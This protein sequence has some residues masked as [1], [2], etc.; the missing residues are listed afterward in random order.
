MRV[1]KSLET[2]LDIFL[3]SL[4][5]SATHF[6]QGYALFITIVDKVILFGLIISR[7]MNDDPGAQRSSNWRIIMQIHSWTIT[8]FFV[9]GCRDHGKIRCSGMSPHASFFSSLFKVSPFFK[10][11]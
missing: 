8:L 11:L 2:K 5:E 6:L 3:G 10:L 7:R 4:L 9:A 1:A